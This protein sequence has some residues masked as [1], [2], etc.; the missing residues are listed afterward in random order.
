MLSI[1]ACSNSA[2][3]TGQGQPTSYSQYSHVRP[4]TPACP[5]TGIQFQV[6]NN[7]TYTVGIGDACDIVAPADETC[8]ASQN[9]Y[10]F[11]PFE[12][13]GGSQYGTLTQKG[14]VGKFTRTSRGEVDIE[15]PATAHYFIQN[16]L[17]PHPL[18]YGTIT[19]TGLSP[20]S[21]PRAI[22]GRVELSGLRRIPSALDS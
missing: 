4:G 20:F 6:G 10:T 7:G 15:L 14:S 21:K 13:T 9:G 16:C 19:F 18:A 5:A 11:D 3:P 1:A 22:V 17:V 8:N 12:F 2:M